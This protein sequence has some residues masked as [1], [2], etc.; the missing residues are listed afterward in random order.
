MRGAVKLSDVHHIAFVL[1]YSGLVVVHIKIVRCGE[2]RHDGGKPS[3][4][5]FPIHSVAGSCNEML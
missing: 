2:N 3:R 5:G 4:F 1:E